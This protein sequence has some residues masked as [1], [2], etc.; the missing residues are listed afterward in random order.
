MKCPKCQG[1]MKKTVEDHVYR[2]S[3]MD[4]VI[5]RN[6]TKYT[7]PEEGS[8]FVQIPMMSELHRTIALAI[9]EKPA[10]LVPSEVRF[11][12]DHLGL[13]NTEFAELMA[14][15]PSQSSRWTTTEP[16]GPQA[17]RFLRLLVAV[18]PE[19]LRGTES[20]REAE[21]TIGELAQVIHRLPPSS[22]EAKDVKIGLR[23][24]GSGWKHDTAIPN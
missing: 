12:R 9:A 2:E 20:S 17:E 4:H 7:C 11:I 24:S 18:G 13:S 22:A 15:T 16:I 19:L 5:L 14:V 10:R 23:R 6:V 21:E 1:T 8:T 3:G